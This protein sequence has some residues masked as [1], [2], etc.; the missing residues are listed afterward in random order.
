MDTGVLARAVL[1]LRARERAH[2]VGY[3]KD[4]GHHEWLDQLS[5]LCRIIYRAD[6]SSL[7]VREWVGW[8]G[9]GWARCWLWAWW[10]GNPS[11]SSLKSA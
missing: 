6:R 7:A 9:D 4:Q 11:A 10:T 2:A 1:H 5:L 8:R 3:A